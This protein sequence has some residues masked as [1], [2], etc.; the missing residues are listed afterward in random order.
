MK[1]MYEARYR[2][3]SSGSSGGGVQG[4][5]RKTLLVCSLRALLSTLDT[6]LDT[7]KTLIAPRKPLM[8]GLI[9]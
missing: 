1:Y 3:R 6:F 7:N 5:Q 2:M 8:G 9:I 4:R